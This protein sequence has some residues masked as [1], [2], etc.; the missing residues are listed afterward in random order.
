MPGFKDYLQQ[1]LNTFINLDEF[2]T[3]HNIGGRELSVV[4]DNDKLSQRTQRDYEG[5]YVG[6]LLFFINALEFG[7]RPKPETVILFDSKPYTVFDAQEDN[8]VYEI[9]LK[10][11]ER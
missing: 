9:I 5:I 6:D 3:V 1:D 7:V 8:G 2:A 4:V 11:S 10:A